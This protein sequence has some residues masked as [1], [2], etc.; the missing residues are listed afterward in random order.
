MAYDWT[1]IITSA[2]TAAVVVTAGAVW[3]GWREGRLRIKLQ[4]MQ[5]THAATLRGLDREHE[6]RLQELADRRSLRDQK[7]DRLRTNLVAVTDAALK[8]GDREYELR[9]APNRLFEPAPVVDEARKR[10]DELRAELVLDIESERLLRAISDVLQQHD[11]YVIA[12]RHWKDLADAAEAAAEAG[13]GVPPVTGS[14]EAFEEARNKGDLLAK[15]VQEV[16]DSARDTL[17]HLEQAIA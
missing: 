14:R 8:L 5:E 4:R 3:N 17:A 12:L 7:V 6:R 10:L 13:P 2:A 16:I 15:S 9:M 1:P 11:V